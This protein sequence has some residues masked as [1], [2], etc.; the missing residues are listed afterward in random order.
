[1]INISWSVVSKNVRNALRP[2]PNPTSRMEMEPEE[3]LL[4]AE[5]RMDQSIVALQRELGGI[6]T[7]RAHPSLVEL[8]QVEH[9][10]QQQPL[11]QLA[12]IGTPEARLISIQVWDAGAV[13]SIVKAIQLSEL[14]LNPSV[15]GQLIRLPIP[16]LTEERRR[17]LVR[18]VHQKVEDARVSVRNV[19]RN[20]HDTLRK[21]EQQKELTQDELRDNEQE[22]Q[23]LTDKH[24]TS[25]DELGVIKEKD[26][27]ET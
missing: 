6:R 21:A 8:L 17:D 9:Y 16:A 13:Q 5:D 18:V 10:G 11:N 15:D 27:L 7:G 14:G 22:L 25:I 24:V 12:T 23:E 1:M 20:A 26:L 2:V 3:I 4:E 19:R